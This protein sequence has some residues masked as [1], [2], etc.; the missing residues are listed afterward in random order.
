M[1]TYLFAGASSLMAIKTAE[2]L[3]QQGSKVIAISTK[4]K[5]YNYDEF[6]KIDRYESENFPTI[7]NVIDGIVYFPGTINLKPFQRLT[8]QDFLSDYHVNTL[9]AVNFVQHYLNQLKKSN[10]ASI[11]FISTVAVQTGMPFHTSVAMSKGA[12]EGLTRALAAELAPKIRVNAVAPSLTQT[13][14]A[15]RFISTPEKM[16]ASAKRNPLNKVGKP[17]ELAEVIAFL[18]GEKSSWITGQ[19]ISVDGGM[20]TLK[21]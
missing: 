6:Y 13:P 2:L 19:I 3:Q 21:I 11:V 10:Q 8:N 15:D 7:N 20:G 14:L 16:E 12:V 1:S 4:E 17:E 9:G 5:N 18:L